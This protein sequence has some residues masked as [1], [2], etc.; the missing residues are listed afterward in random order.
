MSSTPVG[1]AALFFDGLLPAVLPAFFVALLMRVS[2][3]TL[4]RSGAWRSSP[5]ARLN[6]IDNERSL[7][8][9]SCRASGSRPVSGKQYVLNVILD[10]AIRQVRFAEK[11]RRARRLELDV[12]TFSHGSASD[13]RTRVYARGPVARLCSGWN[14]RNGAFN[15]RPDRIGIGRMKASPY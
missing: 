3:R 15:Y 14:R 5:Q 13:C 7:F 4:R 9:V 12:G 6:Q 2:P 1:S 11:A 10:D 8:H